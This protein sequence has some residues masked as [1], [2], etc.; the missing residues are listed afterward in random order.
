MSFIEASNPIDIFIL[1]TILITF[2]MGF[3]KGFIRSL[4]AL[5]G[6]AV[7]VW[8]ATKYYPLVQSQLIKLSALNPQIA[9]IIS[10]VLVFIIAQVVFV[11][12]RRVLE[13]ILDFT[14]LGWL[15][16]IMGAVMGVATGFIISASCVQVALIAAPEWQAVKSSV[17]ALP[18]EG[19]TYKLLAY[20]PSETRGRV[21]SLISKWRAQQE[22]SQ[23]LAPRFG[24]HADRPTGPAVP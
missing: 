11:L 20:V 9:M 5:A 2:I 14:R 1:A 24:A 7:G 18:M 17:L 13:A 21:D 10:M 22:G 6:L 8:A 15:D 16:R 23:Q 3:W 12:L 4:T 19:A